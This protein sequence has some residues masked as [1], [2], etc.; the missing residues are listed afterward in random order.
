MTLTAH[1]I[2]QAKPK[3]KPYQLTDMPGLHSFRCS[4]ALMVSIAYSFIARLYRRIEKRLC[5]FC[6]APCAMLHTR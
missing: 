5:P 1:Q 4:P 6:I 3:D 2:D